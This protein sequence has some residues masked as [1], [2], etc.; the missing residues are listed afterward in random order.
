MAYT[1]QQPWNKGLTKEIDERV[2]GYGK[3]ISLAS[4]GKIPWNKGII[5]MR[6]CKICS[7]QTRR[8]KDGSCRQ[9][10]SLIC[11]NE[12]R[13]R[14]MIGSGRKPPSRLGMGSKEIIKRNYGKYTQ[15]FF[16][17]GWIGYEHRLIMQKHLGRKL[18]RSEHVHHINGI[19]KDNR[20]ENL[21][22][23][24]IQ[25]HTKLHL[26]ERDCLGRFN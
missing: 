13:S 18:D 6:P 11:E 23:L 22:V 17:N 19:K 1:A 9:T 14:I 21:K 20:I 12:L 8:G 24:T 15:V 5:S 16:L 7:S 10:C 25:E 3:K 2:A 26:K 4:K